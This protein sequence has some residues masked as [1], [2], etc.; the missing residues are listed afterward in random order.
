MGKIDKF[1]KIKSDKIHMVIP[2]VN[3]ERIE[4][5]L[6][7]YNE[8]EGRVTPEIKFFHVINQ[9]LVQYLTGRRA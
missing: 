3:F 5:Y 1:E 4:T 8:N 9:A 7:S 2:I 6:K